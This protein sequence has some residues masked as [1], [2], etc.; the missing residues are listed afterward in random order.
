MFKYELIMPKE[1]NDDFISCQIVILHTE[2]AT[3]L[4]KIAQNSNKFTVP[5]KLLGF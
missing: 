5:L 3:L 4:L 1:M 2:S